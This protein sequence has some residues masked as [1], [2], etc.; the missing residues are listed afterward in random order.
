MTD[1]LK[2]LIAKRAE[3]AGL[4]APLEREAATL[5]TQINHVDHVLL[6]LGYENPEAIR[7]KRPVVNRFRNRE[8]SIF[9]RELQRDG[10][11]LTNR[12][13]ALRIVAAKGWDAG[14][15]DLLRKVTDS[16][17]SARRHL[18]AGSRAIS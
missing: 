15:A 4:L 5:R 6:M 18:N 2:T 7:P 14:D 10:L 13:A 17:K 16:I 11:S 9:V 8:L 12:E 3:L 1:A